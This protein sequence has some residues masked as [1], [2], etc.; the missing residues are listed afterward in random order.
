VIFMDPS[1][2][3]DAVTV[4][5]YRD[6]PYLIRGPFQI[7]D[8]DGNE[9]P[10]HRPAIAL[11][12]CGKSRMRPL[13]D[14]THRTLGFRAPSGPEAWPPLDV[15]APAGAPE[16][17]RRADARPEGPAPEGIS[18]AALPP[19]EQDG[20]AEG[21][22]GAAETSH[23][24]AESSSRT[25]P[26]QLVPVLARV[27]HARAELERALTAPLAADAYTRLALAEPLLQ[28][29]DRLSES[30]IAG[31]LSPRSVERAASNGNAPIPTGTEDACR[32]AVETALRS[33]PPESPEDRRVGQLRS[34]L[35]HATEVM[36]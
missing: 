20:A 15:G 8:Q 9:I 19:R 6:G 24:A 22:Q 30:I 26:Q 34:L 17:S 7:L 29:A 18:R 12:R 27:R 31:T 32:A 14:G 2:K 33:V 36:A 28:A 13:C 23:G 21:P 11:C 5:P 10:V 25:D 1:H 35:Q 16:T 3:R 4:T